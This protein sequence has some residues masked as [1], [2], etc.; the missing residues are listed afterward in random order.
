VTGHVLVVDDDPDM[1][2]TITMVLEAAG[3]ATRTATNGREALDEVAEHTPG[4]ILL[5]MLMPI[6]NGWECARELRGRYAHS[7]PIVVVTAAEHARM[8]AEEVDA[9]DVLAKPFDI[10]ELRRIVAQHLLLDRSCADS[11]GS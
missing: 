6:M 4:L 8:R 11:R 10:H 1:L 5:D 3:Y 2:D 7:L 9:D